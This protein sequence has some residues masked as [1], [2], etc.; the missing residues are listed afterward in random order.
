M[1]GS[2]N[3]YPL[4]KCS[5]RAYEDII[6]KVEIRWILTFGWI[7]EKGKKWIPVSFQ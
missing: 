5:V 6:L 7:E 2:D 1:K 3:S 4:P